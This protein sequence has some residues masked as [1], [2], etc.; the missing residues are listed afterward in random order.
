MISVLHSNTLIHSPECKKCI[1][2]DPNFKIL[3]VSSAIGKHAFGM[4]CPFS[5]SSGFAA[6]KILIENPALWYTKI[7][8]LETFHNPTE[9]T[10]D[11]QCKK[12][13]NIV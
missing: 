1:P 7:V 11:C 5:A 8:M 3:L 12:Y 4:R 10:S 13:T 6:S 9:P 2:R